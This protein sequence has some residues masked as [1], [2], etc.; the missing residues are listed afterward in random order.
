[1]SSSEN[2]PQYLHMKVTS[3]VE[4]QRA[5]ARVLRSVTYQERRFEGHLV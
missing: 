3:C 5:A 4:T 1:M 2:K